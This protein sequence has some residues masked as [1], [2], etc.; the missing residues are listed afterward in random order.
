MRTT[1]LLL[2]FVLS[3]SFIVTG[4]KQG[5]E[6]VKES[7]EAHQQ[8]EQEFDASMPDK[9]APEVWGLINTEDYKLKW[10]TWPGKENIY[11]NPVASEAIEK[12]EDEFPIGSII[13]REKYSAENELQKI[14]VA[15]RV[16]GNEETSGWFAADYAPDGQV[17]K[18]SKRVVNIRP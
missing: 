14:N 16:G 12:N 18:V 7:E 11:V 10:K 1:V 4:C 5:E 3:A 9:L 6:V 15:Y 8:A 2:L 17:M 13:V